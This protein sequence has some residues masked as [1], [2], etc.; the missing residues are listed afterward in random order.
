M[1]QNQQPLLE[2]NNLIR[3]FPAGETSVQILKSIDLKIY[4]GEL[5]AIIGQSG[6]G[7]STLMN[8]LG[9]LDKPT[10]GS[11]KV[12][13][14]ETGQLEP[15]QLAQLRREYFGFIFQ[16]YHLLGDLTA[17]GNVEVP[18]VYSGVNPTERHE[19][20]S[21][22][23]SD[24]GLG[25]RL[26]HRPSQLSGGQQQRVSIARALM[27]GGDVILADEPTSMLDVSVRIGVLNLMRR[28]RDEQGI[29]ILYI[30]HD[31]ASA[32]YLADRT[33]VMFA[34]ELVEE[35]ESLDLLANPVASFTKE[36][37]EIVDRS[38]TAA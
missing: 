34:G 32:R 12:N 21:K 9:C 28:L 6:S 18:A 10:A 23:L 24:L 13:G 38:G 30:T 20:T 35:G 29:S 17:T 36:D 14:Q 16:R 5:V 8:I 15:D 37:G 3:E 33:A 27:N 26:D 2:V 1:S 25:E 11:Y 4:A 7:K 22:I 19:R 31:L